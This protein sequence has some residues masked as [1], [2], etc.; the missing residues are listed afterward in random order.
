MDIAAIIEQY[1]NDRANEKQLLILR[2][3]RIVVGEEIDE[4]NMLH[5][6]IR[7][8]DTYTVESAWNQQIIKN[9]VIPKPMVTIITIK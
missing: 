2:G 9:L 4:K 7:D 1:K 6:V 8:K 5:Y 3:G